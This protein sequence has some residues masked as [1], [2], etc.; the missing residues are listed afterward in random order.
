LEFGSEAHDLER[1]IDDFIFMTFLVG[2][3]FLPHLPAL[4]IGENA[5]DLLFDVYKEQRVTWGDNQYLTKAGEISDASRFERFLAFIGAREDAILRDREKNEASF[6]K[7]RRR[8]DKADGN[9]PLPSDAEMAEEEALQLKEYKRAMKDM[10]LRDPEKK[11]FVEDWNAKI[12]SGKKDYKGVYYFKKL[13]LTPFDV[14]QHLAL[15]KSYMEGLIW[16]L[17]YYFKG[18]ISWGWFY[19][20]HYGP[21]L[22]DMTG[23]VEIFKGIKFE[24]GSPLKPF[25]QLMACLPPG[26]SKLIPALYRPLMLPFSPIASFYP[27][28]FEVDMNGKRN[29][30]EGISLLPFINI[31]L[32][33]DAI[34]Q[35]CPDKLLRPVERSRNQLR[36]VLC[37]YHDP[38]AKETVD[39]FNRDIGLGEI[40]RCNSRVD[41]VEEAEGGDSFRAE[42]VEGTQI[43]F[44]GFPS[45]NVLPIKSSS[46][47]AIGLN[48]FGSPSRYATM[49]LTMHALP[50]IS[51]ASAI[52]ESILGRSAF[53]NW[54]MMHEVKVVAV[55][56]ATCEIR[57]S[58][59]KKIV[60]KW[61][62]E[63]SERWKQESTIMEKQY[64]MGI[65]VPGTGG[66]NIG[67]IVLRL[68]MLPLQGMKTNP[69]DG[70]TKKVFGKEEAEVPLQMVLSTNPAPD[71]RFLERG[72]VT[73]K[74][75]FPKGRSIVLTKGKHRGCQGL[76]LGVI[77]GDKIG[78][79][80]KVTP[81]EPPFGTAIAHSVKET[82][83][84]LRDA[85]KAANLH[86]T[87]F[88]KVTGTLSFE[89]GRYDLGLNLKI[90]NDFY[91]LGFTSCTRPFNANTK[92]NAWEAG[93]ALL[94]VGSSRAIPEDTTENNYK[95]N[96]KGDK[97]IW[98]YTPKAIRLVAAYRQQFPQL[99]R[100]ITRC[101][102][103]SFY[104]ARRVF[105]HNGKDMLPKIRQWLDTIETAKMPRVPTATKAM[106]LKALAA[107]Q[108]AADVLSQAQQNPNTIKEINLKLPPM[109]FYFEGSTTATDVS[110]AFNNLGQPELGDRVT[111]LCASGLTFGARGTVV[112]IHDAKTGCVEVVMDKEFM[113]GSNL[114]GACSNFRGKLCLWA[115]L[116]RISFSESKDPVGSPYVQA[117][118]LP[119][120]PAQTQQTKYLSDCKPLKTSNSNN[121]NCNVNQKKME[122]LTASTESIQ[123][124][125]KK[126][127]LAKPRN[128][129][130]GVW[131]EANG[132]QGP[133]FGFRGAGR[134]TLSGYKTWK[135]IVSSRAPTAYPDNSL[136]KSLG[137]LHNHTPI[138]PK[139][140]SNLDRNFPTDEKSTEVKKISLLD[141]SSDLKAMLG[142]KQSAKPTNPI[143]F[144]PKLVNPKLISPKVSPPSQSKNAIH[145][146]ADIIMKNSPHPP[147][148]FSP[149]PSAPFNFSYSQQSNPSPQFPTQQQLPHNLFPGI[150]LPPPPG[151]DYVP[152][153]QYNP[154]SG[155]VPRVKSAKKKGSQPA[156]FAPIVPSAVIAK[157]TTQAQV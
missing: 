106:P 154:L 59:K 55:S 116:L 142:V 8:W 140:G 70:S 18:C 58:K 137:P 98:E 79:C 10:V 99:F 129:K 97:V 5:F 102:N 150:P 109:A 153:S 34:V 61:S 26:S 17:A 86:P 111:N 4:D 101:P 44:P 81:P 94:V 117:K 6:L 7:K 66:V 89:P 135:N 52:A 133:G 156:D 126:L 37:I 35:H 38:S 83:L 93:D 128:P 69:G 32:L 121:A 68:K 132:P 21:M 125:R 31:K 84:S 54:P 146:L 74:D 130:Q 46:C 1:L 50:P 85:A 67:K 30:W 108:K 139:H 29:P 143:N 123:I 147:N 64:A 91:L 127:N 136:P 122:A 56:D 114:Q 16:C 57:K 155:F 92:K 157:S 9:K 76:I 11:K 39:A 138:K 134:G 60:K 73:L 62:P 72:P 120:Q 87:V 3:D 110:L 15:R 88:A 40:H 113:G 148:H 12:K 13:N 124:G 131:K 19:P 141:A 24:I 144:S 22:S 152:F 51:G 118:E 36:K 107:V 63:E 145:A 112:S 53:V 71:L 80:V 90:K 96:T 14:D 27:P 28:D 49:V 48:C 119:K 100:E 151:P 105:G 20:Y 45:L 42:L 23:L 2:N 104:D 77:D 95:N 65:G 115:H 82:Y 75:R 78:V 43:P 25:E 47:N 41:V 149:N 33:K 103:E